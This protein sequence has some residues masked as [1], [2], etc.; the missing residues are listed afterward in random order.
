MKTYTKTHKEKIAFDG[1][2]ENLKKRGAFI[3]TNGLTINYSFD[4][5]YSIFHNELV[6]KI[7]KIKGI[8]NV[9]DL[10]E[11]PNKYGDIKSHIYFKHHVE[12]RGNYSNGEIVFDHKIKQLFIPNKG[13]VILKKMDAS[14]II[15]QIKNYYKL[16]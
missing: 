7:E 12:D 14:E 8:S 6:E 3:E 4:N 10:L 15:K 16:K 11:N 2:I 9:R 1:H 5:D 13:Y